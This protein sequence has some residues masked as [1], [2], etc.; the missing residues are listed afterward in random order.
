MNKTE[1]RNLLKSRKVKLNKI[2]FEG[3]FAKHSD[4]SNRKIALKGRVWRFVPPREH[5][6][7]VGSIR[8]KNKRIKRWGRCISTGLDSRQD[9]G[10]IV[11]ISKGRY[12]SRCTYEKIDHNPSVYSYAIPFGKWLIFR[13]GDKQYKLKAPKGWLWIKDE[14]GV[15]IRRT[16]GADYHPYADDLIRKDA[17]WFCCTEAR[18]NYETRKAA[19]RESRTKRAI[20]NKARRG[21]FYVCVK[22]S[23]GAGNCSL[24]TLAFTR[25]N[26]L[27][28][29]VKNTLL[30][31]FKEDRVV[32][33]LEYA[34]KRHL[35]EMMS[36]VCLLGDHY[37]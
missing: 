11:S 22:D 32:R 25:R 13:F 31:R 28:G 6:E 15:C 34:A 17:V 35:K 4:R 37:G 16:D 23:Y 7:V 18:K 1:F 10:K 20:L 5:G 30:E 14:N 19:D 24:G 21:G 8:N 27:S 12:S 26:N 2:E 33:T 36:G 3:A 29:H 9:H